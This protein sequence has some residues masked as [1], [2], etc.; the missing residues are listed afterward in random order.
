MFTRKPLTVDLLQPLLHLVCSILPTPDPLHRNKI[1]PL[2]AF[3]FTKHFVIEGLIQNLKDQSIS[4]FCTNIVIFMSI[5]CP[6]TK[7]T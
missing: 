7:V 4:Q 1:S 2:I 5:C 3:T 6:E